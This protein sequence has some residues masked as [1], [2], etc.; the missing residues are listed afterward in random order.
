MPPLNARQRQQ[1]RNEL[2]TQRAQLLR[3][4]EDEPRGLGLDPHAPRDREV[5]DAGDASVADLLDH[6]DAERAQRHTAALEAVGRALDALDSDRFGH[7]VSCGVE[8]SFDRL[9]A[10]PT[11]TRCAPCQ[12]RHEQGE[13]RPRNL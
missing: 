5:E 6:L 11:A 4:I 9:V 1:L 2:E 12:T 3:S 10:Q 8:I 13:P 7:C